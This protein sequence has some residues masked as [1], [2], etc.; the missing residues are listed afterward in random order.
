MEN[1]CT[2][3]GT[4]IENNHN[5]CLKCGNPVNS[6]NTTNISNNTTTKNKIGYGKCLGFTILGAIGI[7]FAFFILD[8]IL[9]LSGTKI[10][11]LTTLSIT[12]PMLLIMCSPI[13]ALIIYSVKNKKN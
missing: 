11:I 1:F 3:C 13:I 12:L 4:K 8:F 5:Y 2:K 10:D 7:Y 9:I 6:Y